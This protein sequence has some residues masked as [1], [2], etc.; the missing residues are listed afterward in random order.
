MISPEL[1]T[2]FVNELNRVNWKALEIDGKR[3]TALSAIR[4]INGYT[5]V[6]GIN[7]QSPPFIIKVIT[8][9]LEDS[10]KVYSTLHASVI[11]DDFYLDDLLLKIN[12]PEENIE[13]K[14]WKED[15]KNLYLKELTKG[16]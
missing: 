2:R 4:D 14:G 11:H 12:T 15:F 1:L 13:I 3:Y 6:N 8:D 10:E 7:V 16:E 9:T 5:T